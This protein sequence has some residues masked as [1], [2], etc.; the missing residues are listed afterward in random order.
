MWPAEGRWVNEEFVELGSSLTIIEMLKNGITCFNDMYFFPEVTADVVNTSGMRALIG[1]PVIMFPST[2]AKTQEDYLEKGKPLFEKYQNHPRIKIG[3]APHS[4]YTVDNDGLKKSKELAKQHNAKVH[5]HIHETETEI[6]NH[7]NDTNHEGSRPIERLNRLGLVDNN[8]IAVHMTQ[9]IDEEITLAAQKGVSV[10][11]CP[12]S[13]MKLAS[14]ICDLN[15]LIRAKI[16]V[17]L[18]TGFFFF[19]FKKNL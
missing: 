6:V 2:Y 19:F 16:N 9:L 1:I 7:I 12:S 17:S 15:K 4:P 3:V 11:S 8:L 13:N 14:G 10:S 18:G 5:I